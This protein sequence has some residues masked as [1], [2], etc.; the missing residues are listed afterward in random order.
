MQNHLI[1]EGL[2]L[3]S[4]R[5][6]FRM[7]LFQKKLN[8][9][10]DLMN[11]HIESLEKYYHRLHIEI[12]DV[13]DQLSK[14]SLLHQNNT[15]MKHGKKE[16][17]I[18]NARTMIS[19]MISGFE[20]Q[21]TET[22][23][24]YEELA[25][26]IN[27]EYYERLKSCQN[28]EGDSSDGLDERICRIRDEISKLNIETSID[29]EE[30]EE[31]VSLVD[32]NIEKLKNEIRRTESERKQSLCVYRDQLMANINQIEEN[33]DSHRAKIQELRKK[34]ESDEYMYE[35][36]L[37]SKY[38]AWK[39]EKTILN[40]K[41]VSSELMYKKLIKEVSSLRDQIAQEQAKCIS[42]IPNQRLEGVEISFNNDDI[43]KKKTKL[44][45]LQTIYSKKEEKLINLQNKNMSLKRRLYEI[46]FE[47][48][49][50]QNIYCLYK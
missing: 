6:D 28:C 43:N 45:Q 20:K 36:A 40:D 19:K 13:G 10:V 1:V 22:E 3:K 47:Q 34:I 38:F 29:D 42:I 5:M 25:K 49:M 41:C 4:N 9:K 31:N 44:T 23:Q 35:E 33:E 12:I 30:I 18:I 27:A 17:H 48:R 11:K 24:R 32:K 39:N 2:T 7:D 37:K 50:K 26:N 8:E 16:M 21:I 15:D 46:T 14:L